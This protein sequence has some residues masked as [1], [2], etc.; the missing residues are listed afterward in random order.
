MTRPVS[1]LVPDL[2]LAELLKNSSAIDS[3]D[4]PVVVLCRRGNDSVTA[5]QAL[6]ARGIEASDVQGGIRRYAIEVDPTVPV[7]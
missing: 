5:V 1:Q 3:Q 4:K 6:K 2:P 7:Y